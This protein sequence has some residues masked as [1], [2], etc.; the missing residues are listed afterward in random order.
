[1]VSEIF[2]RLSLSLKASFICVLRLSNFFLFLHF[3]HVSDLQPL[4]ITVLGFLIE[5]FH[6]NHP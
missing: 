6:P 5:C 4:G 3:P 2:S 1:M